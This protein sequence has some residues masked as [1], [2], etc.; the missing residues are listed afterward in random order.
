MK[1]IRE[2]AEPD[3]GKPTAQES[4][5]G[6]GQS[7]PLPVKY[8]V[9]IWLV[10]TVLLVPFL[11][12]LILAEREVSQY[13]T[14]TFES[15]VR[16][17]LDQR[18]FNRAVRICTGALKIALGRGDYLGKAH[19]LRARAYAGQQEMAKALDDLDTSARLWRRSPYN[20]TLEDRKEIAG[21]G[22]ELGLQLL[23]AGDVVGARR[24]IS[25]AGSGSGRP[26]EYLYE[27]AS[28]LPAPLKQTLWPEGPCI[29]IEGY[30][31]EELSAFAASRNDQERK[32][33]NARIEKSGGRDG[34]ACAFLDLSAATNPGD[35]LYTI[36]ISIP[37]SEKPFALRLALKEDPP[38]PVKIMLSYWFELAR[39]SASTLDATNT[40]I[41]G[42]GKLFEIKRDFCEERA[43]LAK[44]QGYDPAGGVI[45][46]I[47]V[48]F[49][50]GPALRCWID[51]VELYI[52]QADAKPGPFARSGPSS[53]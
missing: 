14:L 48:S 20:A 37:L 5:A 22:T 25:D 49:V 17:A 26:V 32:V 38:E 30:R 16:K 27:Q 35:S 7:A 2:M 1:G 12:F 50:Q 21:F 23:D 33:L 51:K 40:D 19:L 9:A 18:A 8:V 34:G 28:V 6:A 11:A 46:S 43:A 39:K 10:L 42:G 36:P 53:S 13:S 29:E 45:N 3:A 15:N 47:G 52:P 4:N 44:S 24:A 31:G 41:G